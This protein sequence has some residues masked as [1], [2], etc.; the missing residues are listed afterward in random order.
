MGQ[1][2][3]GSARTTAAV[4]RAIQHS[5]ESLATL[6]RRDDLNCKAVAKWKKRTQVHDAPMG[7]KH[8]RS[9]ALTLEEEASIIAF[10]E[11][12]LS[13]LGDCLYALQATLPP[14]TRSARHRCLQRH[15]I[16]RLPEMAGEKTAKKKF[17]SY[18]IGY[19]H[20]DIAEVRMGAGELS[21]CVAIDRAS[22][23]PMPIAADAS[24]DGPTC[25]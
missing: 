7:P 22:T 17:K 8:P 2:L 15:G 19:C 18:P 25:T 1:P 10:R 4:R 14:L 24:V 13:P 11:H 16:S 9:T 3:H 6:S 23:L 20:I 5:Q 12:T 21:R